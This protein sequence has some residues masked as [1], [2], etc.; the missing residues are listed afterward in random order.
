MTYT[1]IIFDMDGT[2]VNTSAYTI[3]ACRRASA[4]QGLPVPS[5]E[6][7]VRGIGYASEEFYCRILPGVSASTR[8][9]YGERVHALEK[10]GIAAL[11][12]GILFPGVPDML[13]AL[14][15][16]GARL[17]IASTG[18]M[19]YVTLALR[20][21][22]I[23]GLFTQ[24]CAGEPVKDEMAVRIRTCAPDASWAF[25]GDRFKDADAARASGMPSFFAGWGFTPAEEASLFDSQSGTTSE[26]LEQLGYR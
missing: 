6:A 4:E 17:Y 9:R 14:K 2:L 21:S 15:A 13:K 22:G 18:E 25:V 20:S 5:D 23:I 11:S 12:A 16:G 8:E 7:I 10:E 1:H 24:I 19:E 26:L 3:P